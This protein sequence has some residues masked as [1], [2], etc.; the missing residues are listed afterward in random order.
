MARLFGAYVMADWSAASKPKTGKDS[1][2][3][4]VLKRDVRFRLTFE[5][6]NPPTRAAGETQ[7]RAVLADLK[8]RGD[9]ALIG[10][11]FPLGY[12]QGTAAALK[13]KGEQPWRAMWDFL[14]KE[15]R[16]KADNTNNRFQ[17][18]AK[19]NRLMTDEARPFWGAPA[20][21]AQRW[22]SSTKPAAHGDDLPPLLRRTEQAT[23][24]AGKAGAKSV[25][26]VFGNGT[27]GSQAI[28]G[29]PAARRL[30]DELG[31]RAAVWPFSTGWRSLTAE[32]VRPLDA[33]VVEIYPST[34]A[35]KPE[36][37]EVLDQAQVRAAAEHFAKLDEAG[38]LGAVFAAPKAADPDAVAAVEAEEGWILGV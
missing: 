26:Q 36:P 5:A 13:L 32:D 23:K 4:G 28:M 1:V 20:N 38:K 6:F 34:F 29:I 31:D 27:V 22:L 24:G 33:L 35:A 37:G 17:V 25:W 9:K 12:P 16:D 30:V 21:D 11:D 2:W 8:R 7:L 14:G 19:M 10:F 18:A 15:V 3:I